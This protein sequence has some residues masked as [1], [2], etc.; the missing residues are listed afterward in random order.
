MIY[1]WLKYLLT[2]RELKG[3]PYFANS[4]PSIASIV[5]AFM[6]LLRNSDALTFILAI[7]SGSLMLL[8]E[9]PPVIA[10]SITFL[11]RIAGGLLR[12]I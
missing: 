9:R 6:F 7:V 3:F 11:P 10:A 5:A 8:R 12:K 1:C 2:V 4:R